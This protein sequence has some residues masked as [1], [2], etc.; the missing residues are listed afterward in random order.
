MFGELFC[1]FQQF[2]L[3]FSRIFPAVSLWFGSCFVDFSGFSY[4]FWRFF[5]LFRCV[6]GAVLV[7]SAVSATF[8]GDFSGCFAV[9]GELFCGFQQFQLLFSR[10]FPDFGLDWGAVLE[11][12]WITATQVTYREKAG[13]QALDTRNSTYKIPFLNLKSFM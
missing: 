13:K 9:V 4:L 2:Q 11:V 5:R 1:G 10:I 6:W 12:L 8:F 3:L 7:I